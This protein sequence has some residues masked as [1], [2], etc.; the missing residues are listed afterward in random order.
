MPITG[1]L[2]HLVW[3]AIS[4]FK[5]EKSYILGTPSFLGK[6]GWLVTFNRYNLGFNCVEQMVTSRKCTLASLWSRVD[7]KHENCHFDSVTLAPGNRARS[8]SR[9]GPDCSVLKQ[10]LWWMSVSLLLWSRIKRLAIC[11]SQH[12]KFPAHS[13]YITGGQYIS[14]TSWTS[15][16]FFFGTSTW[17]LDS[18]LRFLLKKKKI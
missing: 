15:I 2:T 13:K 1:W 18:L 14:P 9:V 3:L 10:H 12:I 6:P 5:T 7:S 8:K 4:Q 16:F 17:L 11:C